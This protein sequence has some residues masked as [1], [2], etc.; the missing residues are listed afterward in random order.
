[1]I[2]MIMIKIKMNSAHVTPRVISLAVLCYEAEIPLSIMMIIASYL[3]RLNLFSKCC[4]QPRTYLNDTEAS[5]R[6]KV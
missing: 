3:Q 2:M 4:Y 5:K 6:K 1:M